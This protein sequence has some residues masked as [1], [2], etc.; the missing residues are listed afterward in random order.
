MLLEDSR[1]EGIGH[2]VSKHMETNQQVSHCHNISAA[3]HKYSVL[4]TQLYR[5]PL[6]HQRLTL[7]TVVSQMSLVSLQ[8]CRSQFANVQRSVCKCYKHLCRS[9]F[10]HFVDLR[11]QRLSI[12]TNSSLSYTVLQLILLYH[13]L[14]VIQTWDKNAATLG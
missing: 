12:K 4:L 11:C 8:M 6:F 2:N 9:Q 13:S 5:C 3:K 7:P 10:T 14:C 1:N